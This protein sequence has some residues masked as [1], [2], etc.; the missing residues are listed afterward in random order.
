MTFKEII[1][2]S[3]SMTYS[4]LVSCNIRCINRRD[5]KTAFAYNSMLWL[6]AFRVDKPRNKIKDWKYAILAYKRYR[7]TP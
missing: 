3:R 5:L 7:E 4:Q 2:W 1:I 6:S